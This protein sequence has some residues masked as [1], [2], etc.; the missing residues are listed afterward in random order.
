M[1]V[2]EG[3]DALDVAADLADVVGLLPRDDLKEHEFEADERRFVLELLF[4]EL[5]GLTVA[6]DPYTEAGHFDHQVLV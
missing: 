6:H 3:A 5:F 2:A 1:V 4:D